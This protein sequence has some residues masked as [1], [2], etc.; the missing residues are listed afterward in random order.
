MGILFSAIRILQSRLPQLAL[1]KPIS[2]GTF[3]VVKMLGS[4][5]R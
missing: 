5:I 1:I 3:M 4:C 2:P